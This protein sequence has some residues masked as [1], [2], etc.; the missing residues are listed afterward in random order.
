M[1]VGSIDF[2]N[3]AMVPGTFPE[4]I[5]HVDGIQV[6][7]RVLMATLANFLFQFPGAGWTSAARQDAHSGSYPCWKQGDAP[8]ARV[9]RDTAG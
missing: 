3:A 8:S 1:I 2:D 7:D 5:F 9:G 4:L 6:A